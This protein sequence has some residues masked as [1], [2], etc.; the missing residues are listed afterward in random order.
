MYTI[1]HNP[2]CRKSRQT[3]ALLEENGITPTIRLYLVDAPRA[4]E[5]RH[6]CALLGKRPIDITRTKEKE[7]SQAGLTLDSSDADILSAMEKYP[8]LIERPIVIRNN[9]KACIG[10]PPETV[11]D[12]I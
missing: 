5:I 12:I 6:V 11:L 10:R 8:K 7:F 2:R 9:Q 1:W 4:E 3:L